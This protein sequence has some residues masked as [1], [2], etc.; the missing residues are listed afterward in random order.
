MAIA[1]TLKDYL[2]NNHIEYDVVSH[3]HTDNAFNSATASHLPTAQVAKAV[4]LKNREDKYLMAVLPANRKLAL[5]ELN[6]ITGKEYR[7]V[8]E[9]ELDRLF[10]DCETG[11]VPGVGDAYKIN[12]VLDDELFAMR[13]I[14]I[15]AGDHEHLIEL[16]QAQFMEMM[17]GVPHAHISGSA[18]SEQGRREQ[19]RRL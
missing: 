10:G 12:S 6:R 5:E 16:D 14:Y 2:S 11:A 3:R 17:Y 13:K 1:I 15:E 7:M 4:V 18:V 8:A 19:P 9:P